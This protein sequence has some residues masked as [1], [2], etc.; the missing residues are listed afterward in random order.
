MIHKICMINRNFPKYTL[1]CTVASLRLLIA[2]V[3]Y[4]HRGKMLHMTIAL[5]GFSIERF[6]YE[7]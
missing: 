5:R 6:L 1:I 4:L 3:L 7:R 2:A